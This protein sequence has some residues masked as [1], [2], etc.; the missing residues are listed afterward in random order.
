[1]S[2]II[3]PDFVI[4]RDKLTDL[5]LEYEALTSQIC[6]NIGRKYLLKFGL[7]EYRLYKKHFEL[8]KLKRKLALIQIQI[9]NEEEIDLNHI[10]RILD[11][12]FAEYERN[13]NHQIKDL[14][15]AM[16]SD[17]FYLDEEDAK[18]LKNIYRKCVFK[19]HPDINKNLTESQHALFIQMTEAFKNGDLKRLEAL[20]YMIEDENIDPISESD[21][22]KELIEDLEK[23]IKE[24]K[25][26]FPYNKKELLADDELSRTYKLELEEVYERYTNEIRAVEEKINNLI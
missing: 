21:R 1:M 2:I 15:R 9:N 17:A 5:L 23:K 12:E 14:E 16:D 19:L 3:H 20:Y 7:M 13:L 4:L 18:R 22:I 26:S 10:T 25:D 8:N 24:I 6:P 11:E